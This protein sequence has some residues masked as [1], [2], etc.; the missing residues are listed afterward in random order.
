MDN[1]AEMSPEELKAALV[2]KDAMV[3]ELEQKIA[4]MQTAAEASL[5]AEMPEEQ[6]AEG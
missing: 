4:D 2:A 6:M 1:I 5:K 3:K